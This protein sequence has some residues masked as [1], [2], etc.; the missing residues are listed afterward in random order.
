MLC[1]EENSMNLT[2]TAGNWLLQTSDCDNGMVIAGF[3]VTSM[4]VP[5]YTRTWEFYCSTPTLS[6]NTSS[7]ACRTVTLHFQQD[8]ASVS[9]TP[10][11]FILSIEKLYNYHNT[12]KL[13]RVRVRTPVYNQ[14]YTTRI[15]S[16]AKLRA[17]MKV[18]YW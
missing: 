14:Q 9:G 18:G 2:F 3:R 4:A 11:S 13:M 12:C 7:R 1:A 15:S 8:L 16:V 5:P 6:L 10:D 17:E